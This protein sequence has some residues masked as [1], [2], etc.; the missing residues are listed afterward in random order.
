M[1]WVNDV[2]RERMAEQVEGSA[3]VATVQPVPES[4][5]ILGL[6]AGQIEKDVLEY[7]DARGPQ[8]MVSSTGNSMVQVI[9]KQPP[10]TPAVV[11]IDRE[12]VI[13]VI[14]PPAGPG[15]GRRGTFKEA[16]GR[17]VSRGDFVGNPQPSGEPMTP[18]EFS[19]FVLEPILFPVSN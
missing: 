3:V 14:C 19:R 18:E 1:G 6:I 7:N 12:G 9:P 4:L 15:I 2:M 10:L 16:H 11:E 17:I 8:F 5:S 13:G